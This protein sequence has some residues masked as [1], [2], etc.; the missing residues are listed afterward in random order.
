MKTENN[1]RMLKYQSYWHE[2]GK[3]NPAESRDFEWR[4]KREKEL[5]KLEKEMGLLKEK[6]REQE[7]AQE[8]TA[9]QI[10]TLTEQNKAKDEEISEMKEIARVREEQ[11][12]ETAQQIATLAH[13]KRN[14]D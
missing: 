8:E 3:L 5:T 1:E 4:I 12:A 6:L 9:Q 2:N 13:S 14:S 11:R 10:A 7:E